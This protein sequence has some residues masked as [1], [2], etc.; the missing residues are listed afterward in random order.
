MNKLLSCI[1]ISTIIITASCKKDFLVLY[2]EGQIN[3]GNFYK[4]TADFQQAVVGAYVPLRDIASYAFYMEEMRSDNTEYDYN[5]KDRGGAGYEQ[6]AD[7]LD[8][9]TNPVLA[10]VWQAAYKGI[11]RTNVV[12]DRI[13]NISST[14]ITDAD[15]KQIIGEAKALRAHYYFELVRLFGG[16]PLYLHEVKDNSSSFINRSSVDEVYNQIITDYSDALSL[17]APPAK[18]P[19]SGVV[20]KGMVATELGLVYLTRKDYAKATPLLQSLTQMGYGLLPNYADVFKLANKNSKESIFEVQ[21][22]AGTDG[23]S[24]SFIYKFIPVTPN[25]TNILGV[26]YN[27]TS[28]GFNVPTPDI[29]AAYEKGDVRLDASIAVAKGKFNSNVDFIADSVVSVLNPST[30]GSVSKMFIRKFYNKPYGLQ[31]NTDDNWP[32]YRYADV[33]LM[34]A[35]SLNEQG[36]S[37]EALPYLN[38]VRS[39][40]GLTPATSSDQATLRNIILHE[41]RVELAFENHRWFDLLRT[42]QAI[43]V[44]NAFGI[45]QKMKYA[46]ILPAAYNIT[47]ERLIYAIPFRETQVNTALTQNTGY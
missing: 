7:F 46:Y 5:S 43:S 10:N 1:L 4:T 30:Q 44:M 8:D 15:K 9:A 31:N 33:L 38:Q 21:Y 42:G 2:P 19:Q 40:A 23:Q 11:Q 18:F 24:S 35:E 28:G 22:K 29:V 16:V 36:K 3:E 6:F 12:L 39:R 14:I 37:A 26:N 27:N 13:T 47:N 34:L 17:L 25:T 45:L 20:T 41:R 32:L